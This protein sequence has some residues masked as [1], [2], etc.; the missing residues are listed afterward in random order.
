[1]KRENMEVAEHGRARAW[2]PMQLTPVGTLP[3]TLHEMVSG[4]PSDSK[5]AKKMASP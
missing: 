5:G 1:V 2:E 4:I 3:A